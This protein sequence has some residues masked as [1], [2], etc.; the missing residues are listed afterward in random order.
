MQISKSVLQLARQESTFT[1]LNTNAILAQWQAENPSIAS[2]STWNSFHNNVGNIKWGN[3][4]VDNMSNGT[5]TNSAG[6]FLSFPSPQVGAEAY[7]LVIDQYP[8]ILASEAYGSTLAEI[9]AIGTSAYGTSAYTMMQVYNSLKGTNQAGLSG[10]APITYPKHPTNLQENLLPFF[11]GID[12]SMTMTAPSL[13]LW[14][15]F[16]GSLQGNLAQSVTHDAKAL[17]FR[18]IVVFIGLF[19]MMYGI[20]KLVDVEVIPNV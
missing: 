7:G 3:P 2:L 11:K 16:T 12:D 18:V 20:T 5:Y 13:N 17:S 8:S 4:T 14:G 15:L 6:T 19:L 1:G 9:Q 10:F